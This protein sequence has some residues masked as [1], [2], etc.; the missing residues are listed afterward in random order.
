MQAC[1]LIAYYRV[2]TDKQG[3]SKLGLE[4][5]QAAV[6]AYRASNGCVVLESY[7]EVETGKRGDRP[8]LAKAL[9]HAKRAKATLVFAKLDRLFRNTRLLLTLVDSGAEVVFCDFPTIPK[10]AQGRFFLTQMAAVAELEAGLTSERTKAALA[11][12]KARG[13]IL[14]KPE[15]MTPEAQRKGGK[16]RQD[17][18]IKAYA[19]ITPRILKMKGEGQTMKGI[20]DTLNSEGH[21]TRNGAKWSTV[22]VYRI[23][24]RAMAK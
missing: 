4:A 2:S 3:R 24:E 5:Q 14:G 9:A 12:Y 13:G 22:Q 18:A 17:D 21:V 6:E 11:A 1:R 7:Q 20:A 19:L 8:E 23:L 16:V 15:N 10:G